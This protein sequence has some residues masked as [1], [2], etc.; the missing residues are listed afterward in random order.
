MKF[1]AECW[2]I[3]TQ[4]AKILH[5]KIFT[6]FYTGNKKSIKNINPVDSDLLADL[7]VFLADFEFAVQSLPVLIDGCCFL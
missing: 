2:K 5:N 7:A 4:G 6:T 3:K 1:F